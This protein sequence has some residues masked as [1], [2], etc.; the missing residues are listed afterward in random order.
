[1]LFSKVEKIFKFLVWSFCLSVFWRILA[2]LLTKQM[3]DEGPKLRNFIATSYGRSD[4]GSC[5]FTDRSRCSLM[6]LLSLNTLQVI[7]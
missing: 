6:C 4:Y 3:H 5:E 2:S 1:M 7:S